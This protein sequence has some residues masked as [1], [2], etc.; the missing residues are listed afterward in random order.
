VGLSAQEIVAEIATDMRVVPT[1]AHLAL[2]AGMCQGNNAS[3]G[4]RNSGRT[5]KA[6]VQGQ[7]DLKS[8]VVPAGQPENDKAVESPDDWRV[9]SGAVAESERCGEVFE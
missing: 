4:K 6:N 7:P 9:A 1:A 5:R 3:A 2:W 8:V